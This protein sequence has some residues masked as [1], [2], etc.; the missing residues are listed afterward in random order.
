LGNGLD[1][2]TDIGPMIHPQASQ[3]V[4][5]MVKDAL[6]KGATLLLGGTPATENNIYPP[7][8]LTHVT[9]EMRVFREEI[10]GP[11]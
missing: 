2:N 3:N 10:F 6:D 11:V 5:N 9:P 4:H 1:E 8:L 7:T